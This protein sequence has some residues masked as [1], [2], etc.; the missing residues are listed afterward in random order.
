MAGGLAKDGRRATMGEWKADKDW[1]V[2]Q[3]CT[4]QKQNNGHRDSGW[5]VHGMERCNE[6]QELVVEQRKRVRNG[7]FRE[8]EEQVQRDIVN[9]D[10]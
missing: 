10:E 8:V 4:K 3:K 1:R 7:E 5:T 6:L 2:T 9:S